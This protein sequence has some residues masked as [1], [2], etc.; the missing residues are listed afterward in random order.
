M[1]RKK[2]NTSELDA[3]QKQ[4][5]PLAQRLSE[6]ISNTN[7]LKEYLGCSIQA[8]NQYKSGESRPS[9]ENLY[10]IA[11]FYGVSTD[12]LLGRTETP[13]IDEDIQK[14]IETTGLSEKAV[15]HLN[16]I[17]N[18]KFSLHEPLSTERLSAIS[19]LISDALFNKVI[20]DTISLKH[21]SNVMMESEYMSIAPL[22]KKNVEPF[23]S[24]HVY[25]YDFRKYLIV[26]RFFRILDAIALQDIESDLDDEDEDP[27]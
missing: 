23:V 18:K 20:D 5:T 10:K 25:Y 7:E 11:D 21:L 6:L 24:Q 9:L 1:A 13:T 12:Y 3:A 4:S 14:A 27:L 16:T 17:K 19:I 8:I 2:N 26:Q 22:H 15:R